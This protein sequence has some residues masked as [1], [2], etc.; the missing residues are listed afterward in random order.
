MR[1][2]YAPYDDYSVW[3]AVVQGEGDVVG[4]SRIVVPGESGF[5]S[6][7]DVSGEPWNVD[8][9]SAATAARLDLTRTWDVATLSRRHVRPDVPV[10]EALAYGIVRGL[11]LNGVTGTIAVLDSV[12]RILLRRKFG[13]Q[14]GA[15]PGTSR[16]F[17]MGSPSEPVLAHVATMLDDARRRHPEGYRTVTLG[18]GLGDIQLPTTSEHVLRTEVVDV[19]ETAA[20]AS[21]ARRAG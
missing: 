12:V 1:D 6:L 9:V 10:T 7:A 15:I 3:L 19:R 4:S 11:L 17:F 14:Y 16:R 13:L 18:S 21:A 8:G 2:E 20:V 5:K